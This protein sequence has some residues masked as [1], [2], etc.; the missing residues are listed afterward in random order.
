[1]LVG[2]SGP[3][4]DRDIIGRV[5]SNEHPNHDTFYG[6]QFDESDE[7]K[8][9]GHLEVGLI[10]EGFS[11]SQGYPHIQP[12]KSVRLLTSG[13]DYLGGVDR[14][15]GIKVNGVPLELWGIRCRGAKT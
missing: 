1:M 4:S 3:P 10:V 13:L 2:V 6:R 5:L 12:R 9:F 11:V 15:L 14:E 8:R 7:G